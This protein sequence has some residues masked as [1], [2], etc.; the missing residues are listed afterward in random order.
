MRIQKLLA[1]ASV[2]GVFI[3]IG[4]KMSMGVP[5]SVPVNPSGEMP[6]IS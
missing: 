1:L 2:A 4:R 3:I 6:M 5:V